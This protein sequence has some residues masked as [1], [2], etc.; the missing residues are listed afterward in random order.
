M[1][2][3]IVDFGSRTSKDQYA[4]INTDKHGELHR[5][6]KNLRFVYAMDETRNPDVKELSE[7]ISDFWMAEH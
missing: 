4:T 2:G 3:K 6:A 5:K 1:V 7:K